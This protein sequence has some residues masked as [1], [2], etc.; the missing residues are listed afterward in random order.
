M[1]CSHPLPLFLSHT[2][3]HTHTHT[4]FDYSLSLS[5]S[6]L[7]EHLGKAKSSFC[8]TTCFCFPH[9][10]TAL[11]I[12]GGKSACPLPTPQTQ[13]FLSF[14]LSWHHSRLPFHQILGSFLSS[15]LFSFPS[16]LMS[17]RLESQ[18]KAIAPFSISLTSL[19]SFF[20][21]PTLF[22]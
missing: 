6:R 17:R 9:N 21:F 20:F 19:P 7:G 5:L 13:P 18:T 11:M 15:S 1:G 4:H 2:H 22:F 16:I 10:N 3:T 12:W 14:F 8:N